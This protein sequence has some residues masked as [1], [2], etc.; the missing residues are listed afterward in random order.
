LAE[1][2]L[3]TAVTAV[4]ETTRRNVARKRRETCK[5]TSEHFGSGRPGR[6]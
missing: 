2:H 5:E 4:T 3:K 6:E 1:R